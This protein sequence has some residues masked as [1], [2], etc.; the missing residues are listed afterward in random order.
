[1]GEPVMLVTVAHAPTNS[2]TAPMLQLSPSLVCAATTGPWLVGA[3]RAGVIQRTPHVLG[4]GPFG[5]EVV[6]VR[7][8]ETQPL[9]GFQQ[10]L[11]KGLVAVMC[12]AV[13]VQAL[14]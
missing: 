7:R 4:P 13:Q 1:M 2:D 10:L 5:R 3:A 9:G 8:G 12:A 6:L 14:V 11:I